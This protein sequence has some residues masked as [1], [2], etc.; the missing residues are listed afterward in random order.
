MG[1][2][3]EG[4]IQGSRCNCSRRGFLRRR[5]LLRDQGP[6]HLRQYLFQ[7]SWRCRHFGVARRVARVTAKRRQQGTCDRP[8]RPG[9]EPDDSG[10]PAD[11]RTKNA[12][13]READAGRSS[14]SYG[15]GENGRALAAVE[16][17]FNRG[18]RYA[19]QDL[20]GTAFVLVVSAAQDAGHALGEKWALGK[21]GDRQVRARQARVSGNLP[22][23]HGGP[24]H[25]DS[26]RDLRPYRLAANSGRDRSL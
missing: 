1:A 16:A 25:A 6:P 17:N 9:Q 12:E 13:R 24:P 7:L 11:R 23:A 10:S 3:G 14:E 5:R 18:T 15:L 2:T 8:K 21:N 20:A 22:R 26:S 4:R 19:I